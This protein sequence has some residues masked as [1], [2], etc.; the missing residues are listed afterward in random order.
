MFFHVCVVYFDQLLFILS[1]PL[2]SL[3]F[4]SLWLVKHIKTSQ[5]IKQQWKKSKMCFWF[6]LLCVR[7]VKS[8]H[9]HTDLTRSLRRKIGW[10]CIIFSENKKREI[11]LERITLYNYIFTDNNKYSY[12]VYVV[13]TRLSC[14][15]G[16]GGGGGGRWW[17]RRRRSS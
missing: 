6:L 14:S 7:Q 1:L 2:V 9:S 10:K 12:I 16:G 8:S 11:F 15:G 5:A 13:C 3:V 4:V 17:L